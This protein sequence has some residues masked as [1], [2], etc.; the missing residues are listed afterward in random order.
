MVADWWAQ[1][2]KQRERS[3]Q[4]KVKVVPQR[5]P[6]TARCVNTEHIMVF[7]F[8]AHNAHSNVAV[9]ATFS[10]SGS[11]VSGGEFDAKGAAQSSPLLG[12]LAVLAVAAAIVDVG[13]AFAEAFVK[14]RR[15]RPRCKVRLSKVRR[16]SR[17]PLIRRECHSSRTPPSSL[18][19]PTVPCPLFY[20]I[21]R[22]LKGKSLYGWSG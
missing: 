20:V 12:G 17:A 15:G 14:C 22:P 10:S 5:W 2:E 4:R 16:G 3:Q 7:Q 8:R 21:T 9:S 11:K 1:F 6:V 19:L 13:D 18:L